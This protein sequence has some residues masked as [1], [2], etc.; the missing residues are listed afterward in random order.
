M[1]VYYTLG[2][3]FVEP[4]YHEALEIELRRR[5]VPFES[6]KKLTIYYKEV[7]LT[8]FYAAD[9]LCYDQI[10]VELKAVDRLTNIE[11]G[12]LINYMKITKKRVEC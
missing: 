6:Q 12:Q 5:E 2:T 8:Q 10:L 4:V 9:L 7:L 11:V 3:G 1:E